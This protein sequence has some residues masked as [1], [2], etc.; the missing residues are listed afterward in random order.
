MVKWG[1]ME[2]QVAVTY[3]KKPSTD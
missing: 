2:V 3:L 1:T